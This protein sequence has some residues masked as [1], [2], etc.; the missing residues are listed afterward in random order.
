MRDIALQMKF[1]LFRKRYKA[2]NEWKIK[3]TNDKSINFLGKCDYENKIVIVAKDSCEETLVHE[4]CHAML[5]GH[6]HD[7]NWQNL[8]KS[9]GYKPSDFI[10]KCEHCCWSLVVTMKNLNLVENKVCKV[11]KSVPVIQCI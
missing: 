9:F 7:V 8:M 5:P 4:I 6:Q 10:V 1:G 3:I 2:L 11:C